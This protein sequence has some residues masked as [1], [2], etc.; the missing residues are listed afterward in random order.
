MES[1]MESETTFQSLEFC[2]PYSVLDRTSAV[3]FRTSGLIVY[4]RVVNASKLRINSYHWLRVGIFSLLLSF[5]SLK[6]F[7]SNALCQIIKFAKD[8]HNHFY[9][10]VAQ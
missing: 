1:V 7:E 3:W 10:T 4:A 2:H 6:L 5:Y 9:S 8:G